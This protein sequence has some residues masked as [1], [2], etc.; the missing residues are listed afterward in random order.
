MFS[1][2]GHTF[3]L[4]LSPELPGVGLPMLSD[5]APLPEAELLLRLPA[6]RKPTIHPFAHSDSKAKTPIGQ[7][8]LGAWRARAR[9]RGGRGTSMAA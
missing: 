9:G 2:T 6:L 1:K 5:R 4:T 7:R 8:Q 3:A